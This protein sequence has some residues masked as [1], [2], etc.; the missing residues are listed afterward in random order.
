MELGRPQ[1]GRRDGSRGDGLLLR[2]LG[3]VV[4]VAGHAVDA[5]DRQRH[6]VLHATAGRG[7]LQIARRRHEEL[8]GHRP[9]DR[10]HVQRVDHHVGAV[11]R[12]RE[13]LAGLHV[14]AALAREYDD[15]MAGCLGRIGRVATDDT[16]TAGDRDPHSRQ[17][18]R[19]SFE[20]IAR[21]RGGRTC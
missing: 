17:P 2:E 16:S 11:E 21:C 4:R 15:V 1:D 8:L 13:P 9:F 12:G 5:D 7:F 19:P 6:E 3:S 20:K 14:D 10:R 18:R